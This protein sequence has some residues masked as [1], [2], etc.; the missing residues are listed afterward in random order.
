[1]TMVDN[2]C[3]VCHI[4]PP[5]GVASTMMPYSCAYCRQCAQFHAQPDIVFETWYDDIGVE[6]DTM[7]YDTAPE[8]L[9]DHVITFQD[10]AY[11]TYR[12]WALKKKA[13]A[14]DNTNR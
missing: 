13:A 14:D 5:I 2:L 3:D 1:M 4:N 7:I 12:Q 6:F 8:G 10:G 11:V 9:A